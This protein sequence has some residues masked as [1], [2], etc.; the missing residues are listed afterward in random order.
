ME[1]M[2]K[3]GLAIAGSVV[4]GVGL[5]AGGGY[6]IYKLIEKKNFNQNM[7]ALGDLEPDLDKVVAAFSQFPTVKV[8]LDKAI[9]KFQN[10][11]EE[12]LLKKIEAAPAIEALTVS[13]QAQLGFC[14]AHACSDFIIAALKKQKKANI[15]SHKEMVACLAILRGKQV[16]YLNKDNS[17]RWTLLDTNIFTHGES[18]LQEVLQVVAPLFNI[19]W[20]LYI[21]TVVE[22]SNWHILGWTMEFYARESIADKQPLAATFSLTKIEW[23]AFHSIWSSK[24]DYL[25]K[26]ELKVQA[27]QYRKYTQNADDRSGHAVLI[28]DTQ[29][30][31]KTVYFRILNS[32]GTKGGNDGKLWMEKDFFKS[33]IGK[34][35]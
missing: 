2:V 25:S 33:M 20:T 17:L 3:L 31:S 13:D 14:W 5:F 9:E 29:I 19:E 1:D 21:A 28:I 12:E 18:S 34:K 26:K 27:E 24:K 11:P 32:W 23:A 22:N 7:A 15:P 6:A 35:R 16:I 10:T 4:I 30:I 8:A